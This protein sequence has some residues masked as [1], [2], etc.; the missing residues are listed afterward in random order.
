MGDG[1]TTP[2][3]PGPPAYPHCPVPLPSLWREGNRGS[4]KR[5]FLYAQGKPPAL[6]GDS[7]SLTVP[8]LCSSWSSRFWIL[9]FRLRSG[10]FEGPAIVIPPALPEDTYWRVYSDV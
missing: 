2:C 4:T 6:P 10:P 7:Q 9:T 3:H 8:G 1:S 5:K